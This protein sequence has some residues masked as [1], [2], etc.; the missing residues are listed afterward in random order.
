MI[1][2][3]AQFAA[4]SAYTV[5]ELTAPAGRQV[6]SLSQNES[7]RPPSPVALTAVGEAIEDAAAYPDPDWRLLRS[8]LGS[9]HGIDP[10]LILCG[11]GSLL[12]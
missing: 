9:L 11:N 6:F 12:I 4:M 8:A 3:Q 7:L 5:A 2:P 10:E 1:E